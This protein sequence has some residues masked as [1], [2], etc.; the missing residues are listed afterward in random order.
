MRDEPLLLN[1]LNDRAVTRALSNPNRQ[2]LLDII[3]KKDYVSTTEL[4]SESNLAWGT[5]LYHLDIL[6]RASL[7]GSSL[8]GKK[9]VYFR[10][11]GPAPNQLSLEVLV[12]PNLGR[13]ITALLERAGRCQQEFQAATGLS[14]R[15]CSYYLQKLQ[16]R[17]FITREADGNRARYKPTPQ[18]LE[19]FPQA[20]AG[21]AQ[22][23]TVSAPAPVTGTILPG[24]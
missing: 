9:R 24:Q 2:R 16:E 22:T 10:R 17:G 4:L 13:I 23:V 19:A 14:Q 11:R 21:G 8:A 5:L 15:M 12:S 6:M 18:L 3:S 20:Q 1:G 7:V